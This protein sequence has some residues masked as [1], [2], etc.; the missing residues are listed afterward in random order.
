MRFAV[1]VA[2]SQKQCPP[3][4]LIKAESRNGPAGIS[5]AWS[6]WFDRFLRARENHS[7]W[8]LSPTRRRHDSPVTGPSSAQSQLTQGRLSMSNA[9]SVSWAPDHEAGDGELAA[10]GNAARETVAGCAGV[11]AGAIRA[12]NCAG[13][14]A[15][16]DKWRQSRRLLPC[17]NCS[18]IADSRGRP[19]EFAEDW[20]SIVGNTTCQ[21]RYR[22]A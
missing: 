16:G 17:T 19:V 12:G 11:R 8:P 21:S 3:L 6:A 22:R 2:A 20:G 13:L 14:G 1:E 10:P 18:L 7:H 5:P 9:S 15:R 4:L